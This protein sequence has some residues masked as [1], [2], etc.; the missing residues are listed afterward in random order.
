LIFSSRVGALDALDF[1][2]Y[3]CSAY[4]LR[5]T[6][7]DICFNVAV[8]LTGCTTAGLANPS[9]TLLRSLISSSTGSVPDAHLPTDWIGHGNLLFFAYHASATNYN[10]KFNYNSTYGTGYRLLS[11]VIGTT[12]YVLNLPSQIIPTFGPINGIIESTNVNNPCRGFLLAISSLSSFDDT[13]ASCSNGLAYFAKTATSILL[14]SSST[15]HHYVFWKDI[16]D[17]LSLTDNNGI[18]DPL[19]IIR[20]PTKTAI[21]ISRNYFTMLEGLTSVKSSCS[22]S[23][24]VNYGANFPIGTTTAQINAVLSTIVFNLHSGYILTKKKKKNG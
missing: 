18:C 16:M 21:A 10:W 6:T 2:S 19:K 5:Q 14:P 23:N 22:L 15:Y 24:G 8:K 4:Y 7:V 1:E 11:W 12:T 3:S 17:H 13:P 9:A 20:D